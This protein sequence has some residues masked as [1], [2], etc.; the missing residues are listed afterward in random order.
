MKPARQIQTGKRLETGQD[1][2]AG[3]FKESSARCRKKCASPHTIPPA[4]GIRSRRNGC[5][6]RLLIING[7]RI[8]D[9]SANVSYLQDQELQTRHYL[10]PMHLHRQL[11]GGHLS[12]NSH[13]HPLLSML[14]N[15]YCLSKHA[16]PVL[17]NCMFYKFCPPKP[18]FT[19]I[20]N[21][22]YTS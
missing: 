2:S 21:T 11:S 4:N 13:H 12:P 22:I 14:S 19:L 1:A 18:G 3:I 6:C 9:P 10:Q 8:R 17:F 15:R 16:I 7:G 5:R 20:S